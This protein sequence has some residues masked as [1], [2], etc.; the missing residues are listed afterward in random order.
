MND[1]PDMAAPRQGDFGGQAIGAEAIRPN[2]PA[3]QGDTTI[4]TFDSVITA[5]R[6]AV[7]RDD[8]RVMQKI[9]SLCAMNSQRYLYSWQVSDR[10]NKRQTTIE[11]PTIKMANDLARTYGNCVVDTRVEETPSHWIIYARFTDLETGFSITRPFQQR[12]TQN[13][14]MRDADR[15]ADIIFQIG[16]SKA[17]RNVVVN[18]LST[19]VDFAIEES[20]SKLIDWVGKNEDKARAYVEKVIGEN[21]VAIERIEAVV[22]RAF[23]DWVGR[24]LARIVK[25]C[26]GVE[27]RLNHPDEIW[28]TDEDAKTVTA[29][30]EEKKAEAEAKK[31]EPAKEEAKEPDPE[32]DDDDGEAEEGEEAERA[33]AAAD[34]EPEDED[35]LLSG[36]F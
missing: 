35:D 15:Q 26:R 28:P 27:E 17:I 7:L 29:E 13:S 23:K 22:G 1:D 16:V 21:N 19:W 34:S 30:K 31:P 8:N 5:Q 6:V 2:L 14:G 12:K 4:Q 32:P 33:Y 10:A 3:A 25:E 36:A 9:K 24:D 11:G 18:A 20:K